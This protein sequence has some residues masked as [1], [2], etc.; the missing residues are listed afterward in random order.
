MTPSPM[1]AVYDCN[2]YVQALI[3]LK[4]PG[5]ACVELARVGRV[6][7]FVTPFVLDEVRESHRKIPAKYGVTAGQTEALATALGTIGTSVR[8]VP[9]V[10]SYPRDP[11][12]AH[13]VNLAIAAAASLIVSRDK[14]LLDLMRPGSAD[15]TALRRRFPTLRIVDPVA[16]LRE[17][18]DWERGT[19]TSQ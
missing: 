4:G 6:S 10:F 18:R 14:D 17:I 1:R 3:N 7:L 2:V 19:A 5:A 8:D 16:F 11:D 15:G 9:E 13:Y 12:D